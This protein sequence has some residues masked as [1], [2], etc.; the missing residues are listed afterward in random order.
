M[1]CKPPELPHSLLLRSHSDERG[2]LVSIEGAV[3]TP[4][5]IDRVYYIIGTEGAQRG[6]HA[7]RQLDQLLICVKGSCEVVVDNGR[8]RSNVVL[9]RPDLSLHVGPMIWHEL[10]DFSANCVLLVLASDG[11]N[12]S[13]YIGD[14]AHFS[15]ET[16]ALASSL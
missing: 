12:E 1:L 15:A 6:F 4:F 11:Y 13:D 16:R 2:L 8:E 7:H 5:D 9:D 10:H 3:D 14:Y